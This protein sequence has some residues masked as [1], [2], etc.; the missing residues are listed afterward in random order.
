MGMEPDRVVAV[1]IFARIK[2]RSHNL[3]VAK[4]R[5]QGER[6]VAILMVGRWKQSKCILSLSEGRRHRQINPRAAPDQSSCRFKLAVRDRRLN[7]AIG[8][9]SVIAQ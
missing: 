5:R 1:W 8:V 7:S 9:G 3:N 2:Q 4:L 6:A